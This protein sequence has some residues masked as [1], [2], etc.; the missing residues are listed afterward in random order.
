MLNTSPVIIFG[1]PRSGTRMCANVLDSHP[2]ICI[3][4]EFLNVGMLNKLAEQ[5]ISSFMKNR[6]DPAT[7]PIRKELLVKNY[8]LMRTSL[9]KI[10]KSQSSRIIGNKTPRAEH[11]YQLY[12]EIFSVN[13]PIYIYCAR[14]AHDVLRSIKNLKNIQWSKLPFDELFENYKKSYRLLNELMNLLPERIFIVNVDHYKNADLFDFYNV[15]FKAL[16]VECDEAVVENINDMGPQNTMEKVR[17]M[18]KDES[19]IV[20]L[21]DEEVG[22][23]ESCAEYNVIKKD[24]GFY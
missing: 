12:E 5:Q 19:P 4:D 13:K 11:H 20:E 3:T 22:I 15:I 6:V 23:I 7:L 14:N 1:N 2:D 21:T 24:L 17:S 9:K 8:W 10:K 16:N 18:T